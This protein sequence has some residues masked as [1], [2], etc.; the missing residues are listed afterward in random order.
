MSSPRNYT[1]NLM[2]LL[3]EQ[4]LGARQGIKHPIVTDGR[5]LMIGALDVLCQDPHNLQKFYDAAQEAFDTD[6]LVFYDR[7]I[8]PIIGKNMIEGPSDDGDDMSSPDQVREA[9]M[10]V[11]ELESTVPTEEPT[12]GEIDSNNRCIICD[13]DSD[14]SS[15][16]LGGDA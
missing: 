14:N 2:E 15:E 9:L 10:V 16:Q 12:D 5:R 7:Y 3:R 1:D 6:P 4:A 13:T 11:K 8:K